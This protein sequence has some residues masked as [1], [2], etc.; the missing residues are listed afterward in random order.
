MTVVQSIQKFLAQ[1]LGTVIS[2]PDTQDAIVRLVSHEGNTALRAR[3]AA[4]APAA[5]ARLIHDGWFYL[6]SNR[7]PEGEF[8]TAIASCAYFLFEYT[9]DFEGDNLAAGALQGYCLQ[10]LLAQVPAVMTQ[11]KGGE[12]AL[13]T[14]V[15]NTLA[16]ILC[17]AG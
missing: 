8:H 9:L 4:V 10:G 15:G 2:V 6:P 11:V 7:A 16:D 13:L 5:K 3:F 12:D 1:Q 17:P 14:A